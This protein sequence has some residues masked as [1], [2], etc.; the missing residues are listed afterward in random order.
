MVEFARIAAFPATETFGER[1]VAVA[2]GA[3]YNAQALEQYFKEHR[4]RLGFTLRVTK[5]GHIQRGGAPGVFD[6]LLGTRLGAAATEHLAAGDHGILLGWVGGEV[7]A[8]PMAKI[9]S[10]H[11]QLDTNL[12]KLARVLAM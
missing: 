11:K 2:E 4:E 7:K 3:A 9:A 1:I 8:T 12:L 10:M 5:L 6:R